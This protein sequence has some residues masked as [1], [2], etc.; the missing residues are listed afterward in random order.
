M[1]YVK[2]QKKSSPLVLR[3]STISQWFSCQK[4]FYWSQIRRLVPRNQE[5]IPYLN[6]GSLTHEGLKVYHHPLN[7]EKLPEERLDLALEEIKKQANLSGGETDMAE[8]LLRGYVERYPSDTFKVISVEQK[9][10]FPV[11]ENILFRGTADMLVR[12]GK[13]L[14]LYEHKTTGTLSGNLVVHYARSP[15]I[16]GYIYSLQQ[17]LKEDITYFVLNFLVKLKLP[18]FERYKYPI[19]KSFLDTWRRWIERVGKDILTAME[20]DTWRENRYACFP[21]I[22]RECPYAPL[23]THTEDTEKLI[24]M[25]YTVRDS[26]EGGSNEL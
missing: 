18:K 13:D 6:D 20:T 26:E 7:S 23:C 19:N 9:V 2:G 24:S 8:K 1:V 12:E 3:N 17:A 15:Q 25:L 5:I 16:M 4:K 10:S 14:V 11:C 21:F 22:G